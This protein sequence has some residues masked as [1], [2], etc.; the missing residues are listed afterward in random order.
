MPPPPSVSAA[1]WP[2]R[3]RCYRD[4]VLLPVLR[5]FA[6]VMLALTAAP[7]WAHGPRA[8]AVRIDRPDAVLA[9]VVPT[10]AEEI[11][12]GM[13]WSEPTL[14]RPPTARATSGAAEG[15]AVL[16]AALGL[17]GF[18]PWRRDR[19][20]AV[21]VA[22]AGLLL[23]FVVE[24]TPHLVH[25]SLD[26]DQGANCLVLQAAERSQAAV[27]ASDAAPV[28]ALAMLDERAPYVPPPTLSAP[29]PCGRAPPA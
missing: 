6:I 12:S 10:R 25:H 13:P 4:V 19:R 8:P 5:T 26:A 21:A 16:I 20:A 28:S 29:A 18:G 14:M 23:S 9:P 3:T 17:A 11:G 2:G 15:I 22:T 24:T 1:L 7:A 27:G